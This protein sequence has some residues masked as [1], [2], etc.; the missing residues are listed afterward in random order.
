VVLVLGGENKMDSAKLPRLLVPVIKSTRLPNGN[1]LARW[2]NRKW[3]SRVRQFANFV[4]TTSTKLAG[5][6]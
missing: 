3:I 4:L 2:V 5:G 1:R 6:Y